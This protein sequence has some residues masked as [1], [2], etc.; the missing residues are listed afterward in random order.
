MSELL[1]SYGTLQQESVQKETFGR[2]LKGRSVEIQGYKL[3][4]VKITDPYVIQLSG[5]EVHKMLVPT[6]DE[7]DTVPGMIF[8]LTPQELAQADT[9]EVSSYKRAQVKTTDGEDV[10]AYVQV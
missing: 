5:L 4:S 9:Y 10:W 1:F 8:E 6:G 7:Y 2:L 3:D